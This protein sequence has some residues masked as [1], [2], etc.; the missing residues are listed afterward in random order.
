MRSRCRKDAPRWGGPSSGERG[1]TA[2]S[3]DHAHRGGRLTSKSHARS[4]G[5]PSSENWIEHSAANPPPSASNTNDAAPL[6]KR[7]DVRSGVIVFAKAR[8]RS[9]KLCDL[10]SNRSRKSQSN[11]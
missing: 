3:S 6:S 10:T 4:P 8:S 5:T 2:T 11:S 9:P 7:R 1:I